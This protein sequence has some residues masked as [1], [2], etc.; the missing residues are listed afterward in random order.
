MKKTILSILCAFSTTMAM[1]QANPQPGYVITNTGDTLRGTIDFRTN[2]R[3]S[4][5]CDFWAN[6]ETTC[7]TYKPGDIEGFRFDNDGKYFVTRRLN[8]TGTPE[9]YFAEFMV[10]GKMNLYCISYSQDDYYF[11]ERED[12]EMAR[13][14]SRENADLSKSYSEALQESKDNLKEK[15]EE[16][17]KV[18]FLL[19]KSWKAIEDLDA[20]Q[21][22]SKK[23]LV[24][25]V[26]EYHNDVCTDGSQCMVYEYKSK[27]DKLEFSFKAFAG[28]A[29]YSTEISGSQ[30]YPDEN[31][32]GNAF[33]IGIGTELN[34]NR[35]MKDFS[36]EATIGFSP[37]CSSSHDVQE[38]KNLLAH[39]T[40]EKSRIPITVGAVK[41]YGNGNVKPLI[42]GGV[43]L[44]LNTGQR[45]SMTKD[46][47]NQKFNYSYSYDTSSHYGIYV[48]AGVQ[49]KLDKHY[50]RLHADF[51]KSMEP[52]VT[53]Q[54][55][56]WSITAEFI[57]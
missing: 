26:R 50:G 27:A 14:T 11:F 1:A 52:K 30:F 12:G 23:K 34:L 55:T 24:N 45:E 36:M 17:G 38:A 25:V 33:E 7:K 44:V 49:V 46:Y 39:S 31:Y 10:Q 6:G 16:Y 15:K 53:G 5:Q 8:L 4:K 28:F 18:K 9:L 20:A 42:R 47:Y 37:T 40:Y 19:Q 48:G 56:R 2:E 51:Y 32:P 3:M 13:L 57:I 29:H 21:Y 35:V 22:I 41:R 54:M 43:L